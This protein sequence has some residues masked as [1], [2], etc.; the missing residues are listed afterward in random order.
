VAGSGQR[1]E[2]LCWGMV[3]KLEGLLED[4]LKLLETMGHGE[5]A[6]K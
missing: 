6:L 1:R 4:C 3:G 2:V 5:G